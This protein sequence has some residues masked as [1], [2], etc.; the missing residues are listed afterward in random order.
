VLLDAPVVAGSDQDGYLG[1]HTIVDRLAGK[2]VYKRIDTG[3]PLINRECDQLADAQALLQPDF[4]RWLRNDCCGFR[5]AI[6]CAG[7]RKASAHPGAWAASDLRVAGVRGHALLGRTARK[8][9]LMGAVGAIQP[10]TGDM[11]IDAVATRGRPLGT[12]ARP[13][14]P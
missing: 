1:V 10:D 6:E 9:T 12:R 11:W 2:P 4:K 8:S 5:R 13:S 7:V 14:S 3:G